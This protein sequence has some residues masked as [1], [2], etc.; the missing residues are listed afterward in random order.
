MTIQWDRV[1]CRHFSVQGYGL[2][3]VPSRRLVVP[4]E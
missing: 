2:M 1:P 3:T 4:H